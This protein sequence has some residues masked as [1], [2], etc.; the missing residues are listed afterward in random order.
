VSVETTLNKYKDGMGYIRIE[1]PN[2]PFVMQ[3]G[4]VYEHRKIYEDFYKCMLLRWVNIHHKNGIRTDNRI[5][6]LQPYTKGQHNTLEK[7]GFHHSDKT[8]KQM[9]Q[10]HYGKKLSDE[11]KR[12]I[13]EHR[14]KWLMERKL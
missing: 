2:H 6:N 9:S 3:R 11:T 10:S 4:Y 7:T 8:R 13:S 14:K 5:E 1:C 12:K